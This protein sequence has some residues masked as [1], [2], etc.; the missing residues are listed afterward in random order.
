ME[1][2]LHFLQGTMEEPG[3]IS[4]FHFIAIIPIIVLSIIIP[5]FFQ[6]AKEKVYKRILLIFW[7]VLIILEIFKQ[8]IKSFH[9]GE[10][11]YWEYSI[12]D[13]PFS[14]CSMPYYFLPI[15]IFAD[16]EKHPKVVDAAVGYMCLICLAAGIVVCTYPKMATSTL[17]YINVQTFIHHGSQVILGI[18]IYVWNRKNVTIKTFYRSLIAFAITAVIAI[19][20]NLC[21][22]PHFINMFF[23]NPTRITNLPIGNIVQEKAGYP[24]YLIGFLALIALVTFLTYLIETSI[25]KLV[26]KKKVANKKKLPE[27]SLI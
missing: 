19:I 3:V 1:D 17:I 22:Y 20:I 9:Y 26:A 27:G 23:I 7:I 21:F 25:Y 12:R 6:N 16:R 13:F 11:S 14:I 15:I 2:I 18:F 10:P 5:I 8:L 24:V 4:W